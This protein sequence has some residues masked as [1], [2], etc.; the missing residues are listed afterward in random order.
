[1]LIK[2]TI[3][4]AEEIDAID[5]RIEQEVEDAVEFARNSPAPKP[6]DAMR[7]V[8]WEGRTN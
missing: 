2:E 6:E 8:Y 5:N 3:A 4:T 7:H 1:M